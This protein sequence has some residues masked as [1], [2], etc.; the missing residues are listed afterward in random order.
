MTAFLDSWLRII[1]IL[2]RM[3]VPNYFPEAFSL[4]VVIRGLKCQHRSFGG[5]DIQSIVLWAFPENSPES[6]KPGICPLDVSVLSGSSLVRELDNVSVWWWYVQLLPLGARLLGWKVIAGPHLLASLCHLHVCRV[7]GMEEL[8]CRCY[9]KLEV[10][11]GK[12]TIIYMNRMLW[13]AQS[14]CQSRFCVCE[15][16][17]KDGNI[18]VWNCGFPA[19]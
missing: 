19:S 2:V 12:K 1:Y 17:F 15:V 10:E 7:L 16:Q 3:L 18:S 14:S 13:S 4:D 11:F 6:G 9:G 5:R 8:R